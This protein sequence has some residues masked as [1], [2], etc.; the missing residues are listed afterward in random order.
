MEKRR[1]IF[2]QYI[3][4][5]YYAGNV[6]RPDFYEV[7]HLIAGEKLEDTTVPV[8]ELSL[9]RKFILSS[10][11]HK[12]KDFVSEDFPM[13]DF[14]E[15]E[16]EENR[17]LE[18]KYS[19]MKL[20]KYLNKMV[21]EH[22]RFPFHGIKQEIDVFHKPM[23]KDTEYYITGDPLKILEAYCKVDTC[24]SPEGE[25][26]ATAIQHLASPYVY[27]AHSKNFDK[28]AT[29]YV[30]PER[31]IVSMGRIYGKY[32]VIMEL[33]IFLFFHKNGYSFTPN[34][35]Q[36]WGDL[37]EILYYHDNM[38]FLTEIYT[39]FFNV[40]LPSPENTISLF[41]MP[42]ELKGKITRDAVTGL[43]FSRNG[44]LTT[45]ERIKSTSSGFLHHNDY[46]C[47]ECGYVVSDHEYDS[48]YEMCYEC[49][50]EQ[51]QYCSG[52]D[53]DVDRDFFDY[54]YDL[55]E[56]CADKLKKEEDEEEDDLLDEDEKTEEIF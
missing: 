12:L 3:F 19:G 39:D 52:C 37:D 38:S 14:S 11:K 41:E 17:V 26:M 23:E 50:S 24:I 22:S 51:K 47:Y 25:N 20:T 13:K 1:D 16:I 4:N 54:D 40:E 9:Y 49:A 18:G 31:K 33:S 32:S 35:F 56:S 44:K 28:R 36:Y 55:C 27:I 8:A 21:Q 2:N 45:E 48:G 29:M 46:F 42:W 10:L 30:D 6:V 5:D 15:K 7:V 43:S 34:A 53:N